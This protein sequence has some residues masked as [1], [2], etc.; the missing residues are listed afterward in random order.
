MDMEYV[1]LTEKEKMWAEMLLEVLKTNGIA[2]VTEPVYGA[3]LVMKAGVQ[4]YLK[5]FVP[6]V[7]KD[8]AEE[9]LQELFRE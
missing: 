6:A 8:K 1:F 7:Q 4:D 5:I 3:G 2:C 9:L